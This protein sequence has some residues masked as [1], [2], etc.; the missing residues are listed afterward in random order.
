[1]I[2]VTPVGQRRY[3]G[4]AVLTVEALILGSPADGFAS[5]LKKGSSI[6][7]Q[8]SVLLSRPPPGRIRAGRSQAWRGRGTGSPPV[9][10]HQGSAITSASCI[11][12]GLSHPADPYLD[13]VCVIVP[14]TVSRASSAASG[15]C[16]PVR[17]G[18]GVRPL[19]SEPGSSRR[20]FFPH[21]HLQLLCADHSSGGCARQLINRPRAGTGCGPV[22]RA[23]VGR[24]VEG[25]D[26]VNGW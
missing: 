11:H 9:P 18:V 12:R 23:I 22:R 3:A 14:A 19:A 2:P 25:R 5:G 26:L 21:S 1:M 15:W 17:T 16:H 4:A 20:A 6:G 7:V 10:P 13:R 24:T 8:G